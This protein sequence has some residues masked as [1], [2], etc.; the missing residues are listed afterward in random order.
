MAAVTALAIPDTQPLAATAAP[1]PRDKL[2]PRFTAILSQTGVAEIHWDTLGTKKCYTTALFG[3]LASSEA[4]IHAVLKRILSL[5]PD[6][7]DDDLFEQGRLTMV[8]RLAKP[9]P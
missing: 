2:D 8:W 5:D 9:G 7:N 1:R 3:S 4:G 6:N